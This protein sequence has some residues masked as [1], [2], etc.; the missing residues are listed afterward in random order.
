MKKLFPSAKISL[1]LGIFMLVLAIA[2]LA[3]SAHVHIDPGTAAQGSSGTFT[4]SVPN[5][6]D[7]A[8]T[9]KLRVQFP[10]AHPIA[11]VTQSNPSGWTS[12]VEKTTLSSPITDSEGN[13]VTKV[14]SEI[15][16]EGGSIAPEQSGKFQ[17]TMGPLPD[18]TESLVFKVI[19]TY[20]N[21]E[22]VSWIQEP[23]SDGSEP[24]FPAPTLTLT[25]SETTTSIV[26]TNDDSEAIPTPISATPENDTT[27][28]ETSPWIFVAI[29]L[30][31]VALIIGIIALV[32]VKKSHSEEP[33]A[34]AETTDELEGGPDKTEI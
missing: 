1:A 12:T 7:D 18:D 32:K 14:V 33:K 6:T 25:K 8:N 31:A 30:G 22:V 15:T 20:D 17:V 11:S 3:A 23:S 27:D 19:Q 10:E 24:E 16:W 34:S 29:A 21:G 5:E 26:E 4:F 28:S 2:P 9:T 13:K